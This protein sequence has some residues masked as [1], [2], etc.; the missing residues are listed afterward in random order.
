MFTNVNNADCGEVTTCVPLP[1]GCTGS[2]AGKASIDAS[3][4]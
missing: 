3:T 2:Y 1:T 4:L